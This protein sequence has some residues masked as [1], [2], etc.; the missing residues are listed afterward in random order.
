MSRQT[1]EGQ[2]SLDALDGAWR[3]RSVGWVNAKAV[4]QVWAI[5]GNVVGA[6]TELRTQTIYDAR[7]STEEND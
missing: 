3:G 1:S 5:G 6:V 4:R 7:Q 2:P